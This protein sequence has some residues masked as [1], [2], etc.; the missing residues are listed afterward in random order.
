MTATPDPNDRYC[1]CPD[2]IRCGCGIWERHHA[3]LGE[4]MSAEERRDFDTNRAT[5]GPST[6]APEERS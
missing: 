4:V 6:T 5:A 2:C 3:S 1:F